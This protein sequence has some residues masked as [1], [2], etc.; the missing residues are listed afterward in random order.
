MVWHILSCIMS[1][2]AFAGTVIN[3]ERSKAGFLFWLVSNAYFSIRFFYIGEYSQG[4]LF[5]LYFLWAIR[6]SYV[7]R[8]KEI[9]EKK[10]KIIKQCNKSSR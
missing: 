9:K 8:N 7:W 3:A 5:A 4:I 1:I 10:Q 2:I 6:G